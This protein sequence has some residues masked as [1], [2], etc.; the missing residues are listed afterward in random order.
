MPRMFDKAIA[1]HIRWLVNF[2][3]VLLGHS[4]EQFNAEKIGDATICE[5]A[6]WLCANPALF[7]HVEQRE[8]I[9][10][11]HR[12]FHQK[13]AAIAELLGS[14]ARRDMIHAHWEQLCELSDQLSAAVQTGLEQPRPSSYRRD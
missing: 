3:S 14:Q 4:N 1:A 2:E 5:F 8:Q 13:A 12:S 9:E 7:A 6:H 10:N 11:L